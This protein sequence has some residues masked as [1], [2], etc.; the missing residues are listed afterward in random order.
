MYMAESKIQVHGRN[1]YL[2]EGRCAWQNQRLKCM[3]I[4]H[5]HVASHVRKSGRANEALFDKEVACKLHVSNEVGVC[6]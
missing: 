5:G 3:M 6:N 4:A 1:E 2:S